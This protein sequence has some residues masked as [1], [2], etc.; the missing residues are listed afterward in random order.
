M[1]DTTDNGHR[2]LVI[3]LVVAALIASAYLAWGRP[4]GDA[5]RRNDEARA[6]ADR[7]RMRIAGVDCDR[8]GD[9]TFVPETGSPFRAFC[10]GTH[11][12]AVTP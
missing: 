11:C 9:C 12:R 10:D 6:W 8:N 4:A 1:K 7:M 2:M 3:V 5:E